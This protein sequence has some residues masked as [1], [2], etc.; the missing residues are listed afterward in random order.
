MF[1]ANH[2]IRIRVENFIPRARWVGKRFNIPQILRVVQAGSGALAFWGGYDQNTFPR[3]LKLF[4][5]KFHRPQYLH[6]RGAF[7]AQ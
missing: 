2:I 6:G 5:F 1:S 7:R 3:T 4:N